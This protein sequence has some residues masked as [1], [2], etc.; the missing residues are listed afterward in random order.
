MRVQAGGREGRIGECRRATSRNHRASLCASV[1]VCLCVCACVCACACVSRQTAVRLSYAAQPC[2]T[3]GV[4]RRVRVCDEVCNIAAHDL[5]IDAAI[6]GSSSGAPADSDPCGGPLSP[7]SKKPDGASTTPN[8]VWFG[9]T[10]ADRASWLGAVARRSGTESIA[11][12]GRTC[13]CSDGR[14][15]TLR[16]QGPVGEEHDDQGDFHRH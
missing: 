4:Y 7:A 3:V 5:A 14:I 16:R 11:L 1:F 10:A 13:V 6:R 8:G 12:V 9:P 15:D 2:R